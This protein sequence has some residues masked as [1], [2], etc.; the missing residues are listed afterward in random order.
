MRKNIITK[1]I[2]TLFLF[3]N[4]FF[5]IFKKKNKIFFGEEK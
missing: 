4:N 2:F 5:L 1:K 3:N